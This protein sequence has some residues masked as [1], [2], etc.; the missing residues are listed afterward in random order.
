[1]TEIEAINR[2]RDHFR[3]HNDG[4]PTPHLNEAVSMAIEALEKQIPKNPIKVDSGVNDYDF[5]YKCPNCEDYVDE[6]E[7][8]CEC[9]QA[10]DWGD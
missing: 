3:I 6:G 1:M 2:L 8:H 10:I 4:R 7:H 5:D 9:G